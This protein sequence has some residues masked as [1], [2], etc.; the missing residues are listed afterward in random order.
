MRFGEYYIPD[1]FV[2][3]DI[4][5]D[6]QIPIILGRPLL[7]TAGATIN[8]KRGKLTFEVGE[9][10]IEFILEKLFKNPS[11]RDSCQ[12]VDLLTGRVQKSAGKPPPTTKLEESLLGGVKV[13]KVNTKVKVYGEALGINPIPTNQG[14]NASVMKV[15]EPKNHMARLGPNKNKPKENKRVKEKVHE[16]LDQKYEPPHRRKKKEE[17]CMTWISRVNWA[18]T[19]AKRHDRDS[20][21][22]ES[23]SLIDGVSGRAKRP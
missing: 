18:S 1:E 14:L 21:L 4:D 12:L 17:G 19:M 5:E 15:N 13:Q 7:S 20:N 2:I 23:P 9:E 10:K 16:K 3:M 8:V 22:K 11:L 6:C